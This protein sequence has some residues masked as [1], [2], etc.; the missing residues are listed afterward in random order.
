MEKLGPIPGVWIA[1]SLMARPSDGSLTV[2]S[3]AL[4]ETSI[5]QRLRTLLDETTSNLDKYPLETHPDRLSDIALVAPHAIL[6]LPSAESLGRYNCV[7][8]ALS[9]VGRMTEYPHPLLVAQTAFVNYLIEEK[10]LKACE[11]QS[12]TLI[13]WSTPEGLRHIG[14]LISPDRAESK[15]GQGILCQHG[16]EEVPLRYGDPSG[17]YLPLNPETVLDHLERF[18]SKDSKR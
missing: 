17:F 18:V 14:K 13:T 4:L 15:W 1:S 16:F 2:Q 12:G 11:A 9:L 7:M 6:P 8:H 5:N 3:M 10:A